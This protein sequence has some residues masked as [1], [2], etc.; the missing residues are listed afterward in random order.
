MKPYELLRM[1]A[2]VFESLDIHYFVTGSIAS[3]AYGEPRFT[4]DIDIV[5]DIKAEHVL[6]LQRRFPAHE[7]YLSEEAVADAIH[8]RTQFNIIHPTSGLKVDVILCQ[9]NDFD[10]NRF[11]RMRRVRPSAD[12]EANFA[13]P[14]DVII[15]KL[16]YYRMGGSEKHLRDITGILRISGDKV[17]RQYIANWAARLGLSEIW[18]AILRRLGEE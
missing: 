4:N 5:A 16:D 12:T 15:K 17:D 10:K 11:K 14:E 13:S 1:V 6:E 3:I 7:F 8:S 18:D 9:D 2:Q